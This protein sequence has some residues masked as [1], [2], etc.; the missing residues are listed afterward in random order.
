MK[1]KREKPQRKSMKQR[2]EK[3]DKITK[4]LARLTKEKGKMQ[5]INT[6]NE[7]EILLQTADLKRII[8]DYYYV[9]T[10]KSENLDEMDQSL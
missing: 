6:L 7:R 4:S 8:R 3:I 2:A 1:L 5:I 9:Y 10:Y